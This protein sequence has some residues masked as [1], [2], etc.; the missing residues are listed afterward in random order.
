MNKY[1]LDTNFFLDVVDNK[2][3]R[4]ALAADCLRRLLEQKN[5]LF[6]SS[7]ILTTVA[8]FVQKHEDLERCL[9]VM[10]MIANE[11]EIVCADNNDCLEINRILQRGNSKNDY[12]DALQLYLADKSGCNFLITSD[13][14]FCQHLR[15]TFAPEVI[16]LA[17]V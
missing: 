1:F 15:E 16:G 8:Y 11:V 17:D 3:Q 13:N 9:T 5:R 6:T 12:E 4:H 14:K 10:D 7:D 2:R